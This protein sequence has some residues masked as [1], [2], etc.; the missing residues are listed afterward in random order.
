MEIASVHAPGR[1][2]LSL[3][4]VEKYITYKKAMLTTHEFSCL[5]KKADPKLNLAATVKNLTFYVLAFQDIMRLAAECVTNP[6]LSE[7]VQN[8]YEACRGHDQRFLNDLELLT[9][10]PTLHFLFSSSHHPVRD[11]AYELIA[12]IL[13]TD[14]DLQRTALIL[15]L[16]TA[17]EIFFQEIISA[18]EQR[19]RQYN[20]QYFTRLHHDLTLSQI[21]S[22]QSW[23]NQLAD[24]PV[25]LVELE[26]CENTVNLTFARM[27]KL[28]N[29]LLGYLNSPSDITA[30]NQQNVTY[31]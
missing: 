22:E 17:G 10:I 1:H 26:L 24:I 27:D 5:L 31:E 29:Y 9:E 28:A 18:F 4:D 8:H 7:I 2:H 20:L 11:I 3:L 21:K 25:G 6:L 15:S 16:E 30:I 19:D 23:E 12:D 14:T 13:R